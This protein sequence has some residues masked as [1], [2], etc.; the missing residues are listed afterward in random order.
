MNSESSQNNQSKKEEYLNKLSRVEAEVSKISFDGDTLQMKE[1]S[2]KVLKKWDDA[3]NEIYGVLKSQL[4]D[5]EMESLKIE[6]REWIAIR[7]ASAEESA[8]EFE[9]GTMYG[10]EYTEVLG[11][12]T[13]ER[14]YDLVNKYM[15]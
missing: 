3:L 15:K 6:Q 4:S 2:S 7:D 12:I 14:C 11:R 13:K 8:S 10:L 5:S 1:A 9:G